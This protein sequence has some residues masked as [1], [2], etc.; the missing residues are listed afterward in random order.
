VAFQGKV[1]TLMV[2]LDRQHWGRFDERSGKAHSDTQRAPDSEDLLNL[3][4]AFA[5]EHGAA[6]HAL[7]SADMPDQLSAAAVFRK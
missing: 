6:V 1:D 7:R 3:A 5:L 4:A 2:A